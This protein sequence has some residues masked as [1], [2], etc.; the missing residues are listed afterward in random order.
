MPSPR[1]RARL[2]A[3][4][5]ATLLPSAACDQ[6]TAALEEKAQEVAE[7]MTP[8]PEATP[9]TGPVLTEDEQ[10]AAKLSLYIECQDRASQR[11]RDSWQRYDERVKDDGTPRKKGVEPYLYKIDSELTP[12]EEAVAKGPTTAPPMPDVEAVMARWLEHA[13]AFATT[14]V[15][16]DTYYEQESYED[17][18]WAKG[19]ALAPGFRAA[20]EA[21]EA[22]DTELAA[23]IDVRK[24]VVDRNMLA[25]IEER[26]GKDLEWHSRNVMLAAKAYVRCASAD[27]APG[28]NAKPTPKAPRAEAEGCTEAFATL[29]QAETGFRDEL[30]ANRAKADGVFWMSAFEVSVADFFAEANKTARPQGKGKPVPAAELDRLVDEYDGLV[31]DSNNLRFPR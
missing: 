25:L 9:P 22:A 28:R 15:A 21:W 24:D 30:E 17:D 11:M 14:T 26:H 5:A 7:E 12:C 29:E 4:L 2:R 6:L 3:L 23:L 19:K 20:Y 10:L 27:P 1:L 13:R 8:P 16:L 31:S 18:D